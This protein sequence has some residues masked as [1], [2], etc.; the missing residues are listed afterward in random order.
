MNETTEPGTTPTLRVIECGGCGAGL[1]VALG[2]HAVRC[3]FCGAQQSV[4]ELDEAV[5]LTARTISA[6]R[7]GLDALRAAHARRL[8][9]TTTQQVVAGFAWFL[10]PGSAM[11]VASLVLLSEGIVSEAAFPILS[12][13]TLGLGALGWY[14]SKQWLRSRAVRKAE[15]LTRRAHRELSGTEVPSHCPSCGGDVQVPDQ[16]AAL[17]C[18]FCSMPLLASDGM[19]ALWAE[20]AEERRIEWLIRADKLL[21]RL[22]AREIRAAQ[23]APV[24]ISVAVIGIALVAGVGASMLVSSLSLTRVDIDCRGVCRVDGMTCLKGGEMTIYLAPGETKVIQPWV[25]PGQWRTE[26]ITVPKGER[27][28][29]VCPPTPSA[30]QK[31]L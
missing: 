12:Y 11:C 9:P 28:V 25:A 15:Q 10:L 2:R 8:E 22:R 31:D 24:T 1:P 14:C 7:E 29:F 6:E 5:E 3:V 18:P 4:P 20:D 13:A 27:R 17:A 30:S 16:A 19:L 23:R 26:W 21:D